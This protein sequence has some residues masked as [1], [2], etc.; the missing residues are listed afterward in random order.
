M[1][2]EGGLRSSESPLECFGYE[3]RRLRDEAGMTQEE[4]GSTINYSG[5]QVSAVENGKR[6]PRK[7]FAVACDAALNAGGYLIE[8]WR[9]IRHAIHRP[10]IRSYLDLEK[11]VCFFRTFE[12][13][14]VP[15]LL[16]TEAYARAVI[17]GGSPADDEETIDARVTARMERQ[18]IL[19]GDRKPLL[20]A[21]IEENVF[22]RPIGGDDVMREQL[23]H[24]IKAAQ[25]PRITVQVVPKTV[26]AYPGM[27]G[28]ITLLSFEEL[29]EVA[30]F[31]HA[32]GGEIVNRPEDVVRASHRFDGVR[33]EAL[34]K[35]ASIELM[36]RAVERWA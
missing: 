5:A 32:G 13:V 6:S 20:L 26:G 30:Y 22:Y 33:A 16:Q 17:R 10:V 11:D 28:P 15:G 21:I 3:L 34:P 12:L 7:D 23:L 4:L 35:G 2:V 18:G 1:S 31:D 24:L 25:C 9:N 36:R 14:F 19:H 27:E 8:L 29:P